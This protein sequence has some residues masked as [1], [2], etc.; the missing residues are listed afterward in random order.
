MWGKLKGGGLY[1]C[2]VWTGGLWGAVVSFEVRA[3]KSG[4]GCLFRQQGFKGRKGTRE[5]EAKK[6]LSQ[7]KKIN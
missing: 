6:R 7:E 2:L 5:K 3:D 1:R 4:I